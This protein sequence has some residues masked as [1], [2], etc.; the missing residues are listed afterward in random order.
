MY[1]MRPPKQDPQIYQAT[2]QF[3]YM[4]KK[5]LFLGYRTDLT[6]GMTHVPGTF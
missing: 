1:L 3:L 6:V 2:H 5:K 4:K